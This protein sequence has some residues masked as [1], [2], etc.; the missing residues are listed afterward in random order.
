MGILSH[1]QIYNL[2]TR[3]GGGRDFAISICEGEIRPYPSQIEEIC[4]GDHISIDIL[5]Y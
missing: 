3:G 2:D 4:D 1:I 5:S